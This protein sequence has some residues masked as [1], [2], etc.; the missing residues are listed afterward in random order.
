[1]GAA[2]RRRATRAHFQPRRRLLRA[3]HGL[4]PH[5]D[6]HRRPR[7]HARRDS[8]RGHRARETAVPRARGRVADRLRPRPGRLPDR[9]HRARLTR[10]TRSL[11]GH[12][13][14]PRR[15]HRP[16]VELLPAGRLHLGR[17]APGGSAR[18]R[19]TRPSG[20]ARGWTPTGGSSPAPME[21]ALR[22]ARALRALLP[23][24]RRRRRP[25][26]RHLGDPRRVQPGRVPRAARERSGLEVRVLPREE[27]ARYGY[28]A[29][30][31]STTLTD[32]VALDLGGGS[33][34][35]TRVAGPLRRRRALVAAR[36]GA[37]DRALPRRTSAPSQAD[38]GAARA[39]REPSTLAEAPWVRRA[40]GGRLVG[41]GGTVRNLAVAAQLAAG[42]PLLRRAGV[43]AHARRARRRSSSGS[44]DA[45]GG[46]ARRRARASSRRAPT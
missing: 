2:W 17:R 41:I 1:M 29:A 42:V 26:R 20:S 3:R 13:R 46:R 28:L 43:R 36:R 8:P 19:S 15:G 9:A 27:E 14:A 35:L 7:R 33:M 21:R 4:Q 24:D 22:D 34:Q 23:R 10:A 39:R 30:V 16:R 37:H 25:A 18:T 5:R 45:A 38:Q 32:G 44:P 31:N 6:H 11:G 12:G 40:R